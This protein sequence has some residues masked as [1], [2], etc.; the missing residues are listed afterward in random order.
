[1][2]EKLKSLIIFDKK[3]GIVNSNGANVLVSN[4]L[5]LSLSL[6]LIFKI[7]LK[8]NYIFCLPSLLVK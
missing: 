3:L 4:I 2:K 7:T 1:M 5:S 8:N 6:S